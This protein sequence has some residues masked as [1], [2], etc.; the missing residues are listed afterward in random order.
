MGLFSKKEKTE[1]LKTLDTLSNEEKTEVKAIAKKLNSREITYEFRTWVQNV[2]D[3]AKVT[4]NIQQQRHKMSVMLDELSQP[5]FTTQYLNIV[6][7]IQKSKEKCQAFKSSEEQVE[8]IIS[9]LPRM[10]E[11]DGVLL[12]AIQ[13][14]RKKYGLEV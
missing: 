14:R 12:L 1:A 7:I 3:M 6:E 11:Y 8:N 4:P 13:E 5:T 9:W 10:K 2:H